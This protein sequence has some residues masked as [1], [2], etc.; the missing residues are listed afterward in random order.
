MTMREGRYADTAGSSLYSSASFSLSDFGMSESL[1]YL[2]NVF[3]FLTNN[4][5]ICF[6]NRELDVGECL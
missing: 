2:F 6:D 4:L 1:S 5:I 3:G